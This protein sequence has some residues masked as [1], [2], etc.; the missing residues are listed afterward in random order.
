MSM[1]QILII[2]RNVL[3]YDETRFEILHFFIFFF[4]L[5]IVTISQNKEHIIAKNVADINIIVTDA[6]GT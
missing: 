1:R 3:I 2:V 6:N 5:F 4:A